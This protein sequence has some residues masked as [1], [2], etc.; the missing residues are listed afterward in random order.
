MQTS[1]GVFFTYNFQYGS[2]SMTEE[3]AWQ[4]LKSPNTR[5][6]IL[7]TVGPDNVPQ[8]TPIYFHIHDGKIYFN[9][10]K[11][12]PK[13][14]LR[15]ILRNPNVCLTTDRILPDGSFFWISV[16]GTARVVANE[17]STDPREKAFLRA[18]NERSSQKYDL[19]PRFNQGPWSGQTV[20][21]MMERI[22]L[23]VT[24]FKILSY[25][26]RKKTQELFDKLTKR[27]C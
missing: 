20:K 5:T 26:V 13:K 12:P 19:G 9:A 4:F 16:S 8:A 1:K 27:E 25:D 24:P 11:D 10:K 14:K 6:L 15:N 18:Y 23:E 7:S 22:Y 3:E 2:S 17:W 21:T